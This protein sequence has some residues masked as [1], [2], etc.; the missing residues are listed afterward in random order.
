MEAVRQQYEMNER[1]KYL[2]QHPYSIWQG[3]DGKW[4]TYLPENEG[5]RLCKRTSEEAINDL[6]I[7]YWK[8]KDTVI[9]IESVFNEWNDRRLELKK[10]SA[11][12]HLRNKQI[13]NR[14]YNDIKNN[15]IEIMTSE[16]VQD[17]LECEIAKRNLS[18]KAFANLKSIT[19]GFLKRA[20]KR[21]LLSYSIEEVFDDLD[22][23]DREF[24]SQKTKDTEQ[25]FNEIDL[26]LV[27]NYLETHQDIVNLAILFMI[28]TGARVGEVVSLKYE[29]YDPQ[30]CFFTVQRTE[31]RYK[32]E[33]GNYCY[34]VKDRPK[35]EAGIRDVMLPSQYHWI[36]EAIRKQN[37]SKEF[38]FCK[39]GVR[40]HSQ[41]VRRRL[42]RICNQLGI[43]RKSPHKAR[44]TF[45]SILLENGIDEK[46]IEVQLGHTTIATTKKH[47][48][49]DRKTTETKQN[50]L[51]SIPDFRHV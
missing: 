11:A 42:Y 10:I 36:Y 25:V 17:F 45:A 31:T 40:I 37:P 15:K 47:Y 30:H 18:S 51:D 43:D 5:R 48:F 7:S 28:V 8:E 1:K 19:R 34:D 2:A 21:G 27:L 46:F 9:T 22:V 20:K 41:W 14:H 4:R 6:V 32:N 49:K 24:C 23:S 35:T 50:I 13:F 3:T 39:D 38:L 29:D 12:T 26:P 16:Y 44:K 33:E